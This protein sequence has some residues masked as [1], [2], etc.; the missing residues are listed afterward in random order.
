[1]G[2]RQR[3]ATRTPKTYRIPIEAYLAVLAIAIGLSVAL[4]RLGRPREMDY[5]FPHRFAVEDAAFLPSAHA[6]AD[7]VMV[8]ANRITLLENGDQFFPAMLAAVDQ[9]RESV[10]LESYIFWSGEIAN[11]FIDALGAA[12]R[13]GVE[14]RVMVDALGSGGKFH[15]ADRERL[16]RAGCALRF[17]H[18][19]RPWMIDAINHRTHRR[20]LVVD[21]RI[22]FTG[23]AGIGDE[24][25]GNADAPRHWRETQVRAEGPVV[26]QLQAAFQENW[27]DVTGEAL[28]GPKFFP[29]IPSAGTTV[30]Q[31]VSSSW[32]APSSA[33]K[34]LYS[35][36]ISAARRRLLI[37]NSYFLPDAETRALLVAAANRG[38]DVEVIV[39]GK[40][41]DVPATKAG[42]RA[43]FGE[44]LSGGVRIFEYSP[45]MFHPKTMVVDG[46]FAT[47]GST[48]F[49]NRSFRLNDEI[50]LTVYDAAIGSRLERMFD[51]DR[52]RSHPYTIAEYRRRSVKDRLFEWLTLPARREL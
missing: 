16:V 46:V 35:V 14:V 48:N 33:T 25:L 11:R 38:V 51:A 43:S 27:S 22:G 39:P 19:L 44:L 4:S 17:F 30:A 18:P 21:G 3:R 12:V 13:R 7:P 41:N 6:L 47:V 42:G 40:L 15:S 52:G 29:K 31:V 28:V 34:L 23:G 5:A 10:N 20:L 36:A 24:W 32:E 50:N 1:M 8:G 26:A 49:D 37:S 9:A 2:L 45:T